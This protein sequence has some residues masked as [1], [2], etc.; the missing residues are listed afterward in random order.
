MFYGYPIN[1]KWIRV[2][3]FRALPDTKS[4]ARR[5]AYDPP[6]SSEAT[7]KDTGKTDRYQILKKRCISMLRKSYVLLKC[8]RHQ[9]S[10]YCKNIL[11][12]IYKSV[13]LRHLCFSSVVLRKFPYIFNCEKNSN[14]NKNNGLLVNTH[15]TILLVI[16]DIV[17][18]PHRNNG[19][20]RWNT[21]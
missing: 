4:L 18:L 16:S 17:I 11:R 3:F 5:Q 8:F 10:K 14:N 15:H 19:I 20:I 12:F 21:N 1:S 9:L 7:L 6:G 13:Q 2:I